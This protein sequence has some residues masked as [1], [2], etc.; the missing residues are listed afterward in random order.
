MK[1]ALAPAFAGGHFT[2]PTSEEY[3]ALLTLL[4]YDSNLKIASGWVRMDGDHFW[5]V[6]QWQIQSMLSGISSEGARELAN[7]I[8]PD[9][10]AYYLSAGWNVTHSTLTIPGC[11]RMCSCATSF[12][13]GLKF[14]VPKTENKV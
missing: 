3:A 7:R 1:P 14:E 5:I 12:H 10:V 4:C 8:C 11:G 6:T 13:A 9:L 2:D